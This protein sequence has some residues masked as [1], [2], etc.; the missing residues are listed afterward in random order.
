MKKLLVHVCCGPCFII[1]YQA[2]L[3]AG[4]A[5]SAHYYNPNIHPFSEYEHRLETA[6]RYCQDNDIDFI[7]DTYRLEDYFRAIAGNEKKPQRCRR[8]M[9]LRLERTAAMAKARGFNAFSTSLLV[10][11]YQLHEDIK[12]IGHN[13]ADRYQVKFIYRDFR[14]L[15]HDGVVE[16]R[17]LELYRQSFCGCVFSERERIL[18]KRAAKLRRRSKKLITSKL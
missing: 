11:P 1:P 9:R 10:S 2:Y 7:E 3:N 14:P 5:T 18:E 17:R 6:R 15:Y 8:C 4:F 12:R 16:S 13:L